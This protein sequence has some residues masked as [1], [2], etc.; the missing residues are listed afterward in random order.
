MSNTTIAKKNCGYEPKPVHPTCSNCAEFRSERILPAWMIE[1]NAAAAADN[2]F[3][4]EKN[5]VEKNMRCAS[6][7]FA[8]T[9]TATCKQWQAKTTS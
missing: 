8:V 3:T 9:K 2:T 4:V 5:G 1:S 7:G 6:F